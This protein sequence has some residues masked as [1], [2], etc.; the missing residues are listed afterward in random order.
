VAE[1]CCGHTRPPLRWCACGSRSARSPD[2]HRFLG[3]GGERRAA[4][5]KTAPKRRNVATQPPMDTDPLDPLDPL[6]RHAKW[7]SCS[8]R[9]RVAGGG[10]R[11]GRSRFGCADIGPPC[12]AS[13]REG[14]A[15]H[16]RHARA[17]S[18]DLAAERR[19]YLSEL[20]AHAHRAFWLTYGVL[21]RVPGGAARPD[22][23]GE[24]V[25]K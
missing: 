16:A 22:I 21:Q 7:R 19:I 8:R 10:G 17:S 5:P 18:R 24:K 25:P 14:H 20:I 11:A 23:G 1:R 2:T 9:W 15:P 3:R 6:A 13:L 4:P 12:W